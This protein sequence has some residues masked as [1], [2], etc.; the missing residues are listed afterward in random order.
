AGIG[1]DIIVGFPGETDAQFMDTY[2]L[3]KELPLTH[4]HVFPFS[5]RKNTI[6]GRMEDHIQHGVKKERARALLALGEAKLRMF[7]EDQIG[8]VAN[9][10]YERKKKHGAWEGYTPNYVRVH[11]LSP[12]DLKNR[13]V[14]TQITA[15]NGEVALGELL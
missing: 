7:A 9:V 13:I 14:K 15:S 2:N 5:K 1:A 12:L 3:V 10:L 11:T 6:A 4:F 8:N